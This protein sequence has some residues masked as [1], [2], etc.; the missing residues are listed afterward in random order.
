MNS[1]L[2]RNPLALA[3][4]LAS[5]PLLA[6][7]DVN[8][9]E[10]MQVIGHLVRGEQR[11]L[12]VQQ[13][14]NRVMSV[15]S[16]T[17]M[18][19]LPDRNAAEALQR[20]PGVSIE[21]DQGE[22]RFVAVRGLPSQW[23]STTLNGDRIP[24]AEEETTSRATAFDFFPTEMIQRIEVSKTLTADMEGDAIG[25]SVNFVTRTA[26]EKET[27]HISLAD[28]FN[29][30]ADDHGGYNASALYGNRSEDGRLGFLVNG[31]AWKREWA[32]DNYEPRRGDDGLGIYRLEL[33]D[34]TGVRETYGINSAI[35]FAPNDDH[36]FTLRALY[37]TLQDD[38]THFKHRYRFDKD[39]V[40][41]QHIHN[42]LITEMS[43]YQLGGEHKLNENNRWDWTLAT[44]T[45]EFKY[46]CIPNCQDNS[47]F[48]VR[49][50]QKGVG[51]TGLEDRG[52]GKKYAYNTIDGG[53]DDADAISNHLPDNFAMDPS[54]QFLS[55]VELYKVYV[56][57]KDKLV[58]SANFNSDVSD[59]LAL[60]FGAKFREKERVATY[61]DEFYEWNKAAGPV[62]TLADFQLIDQ[63]GRNDYLDDL[64]IG[65]EYQTDF[66]QVVSNK[67][68][69][70]WY[71]ANR[72]NLVLVESESALVSNGAALGR[73]FNVQEQHAAVYGMATWQLS[74]AWNLIG[75]VR[76]EQTTTNVA[77]QVLVTDAATG[78][79]HLQDSNGKKD[80]MSVLP[81][82][83]VKYS[84]DDNTNIRF[85][86]TR[87][88]TR[89]DFGSLNP[90][91]TYSE[92]DNE[93]FSG[94]SQLD[95]TYSWNY[96]LTAEHYFGDIGL[97]SGGIFY[98]DITDPIFQSSSIGDFNGKTGV[99][100]YRPENGADAKLYGAE[101][102][103]NKRF[104]FLPGFLQHTGIQTNFTA[105]N[106]SMT[107]EG[108]SGTV[109]IPRQA[110]ELY[111]ITFYY[112][113]G[114][115][116]ARIA[117][118]QK[119]AY[120]EEHGESAT[121][122][123]YYGDYTS[124]DFS[125]SFQITEQLMVFAELNNLTD[126]PL[127]YYIG[128]S[129]RPKQIEYYGVRGQAGIKYGF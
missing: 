114:R 34:Y 118:N 105:M 42:E 65:N 109:P 95:P 46:G 27:F 107:I 70:D 61:S 47:Y 123:N 30:K 31:T 15:V 55:W 38:E 96:D 104:T 78:D 58:A 73:N 102:A 125:T 56:E 93:F 41:L 121:F 89:P 45:N 21:R 81:S 116:S 91:G 76:V 69:T 9:I 113:D 82:A 62:P 120:V 54:K 7:S 59:S 90:G 26:P 124:V 101:I 94:N 50:D 112:D 117:V 19:T 99:N 129:D 13:Q 8:S 103:L 127:S 1:S 22:G 32:T 53:S 33:R 3:V 110:D 40:E 16:A 80:Y 18:A 25:G 11:A 63:P 106:S 92:A 23:N 2:I 6:N 79:S 28:S 88:F 36:K 100:F 43:G 87:S 128:S 86:V 48:V 4:A 29:E 126:E 85:S 35:E 68:L 17:D 57:E 84:V 72:Q 75:G 97:L 74:D 60:K 52:T 64:A 67:D 39:R 119:G 71:N 24:T 66:S 5:A 20:V 10:E 51:Y 14:A 77:G 44:Y 122:D 111:N 12:E 98:K 37:G 49:F 115:F 108:R 83:Q